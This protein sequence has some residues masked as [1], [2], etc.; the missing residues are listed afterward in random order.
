MDRPFL[1]YAYA[2]A[3][4]ALVA[5]FV[6]AVGGCRSALTTAAYLVKGNTADAEFDG[7]KGKKVAVVCR[8]LANLTFRDSNVAKDL[9][10]EVNN[11]LKANVPKVKMID[12]QKVDLW[13]DEHGDWDDYAEIGQ[14]SELGADVVVGV[15]LHSFSIYQSQVLYQGKANVALTVYDCADGGQV[16]F[17]KELPQSVYPPN[18]VIPTSEKQESEFR[19]EYLRIVADM[20]GRHFYAHDRHADYALDARALD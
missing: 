2:A 6:P 5:S 11:L 10:R 19:R 8:P 9:A 14:D 20:I 3:L 15:D 12:Q 1:R 4:L 16:V 17:R 18:A 13:L 7:L